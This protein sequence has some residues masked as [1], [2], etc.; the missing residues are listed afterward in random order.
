MSKL[1]EL[2]LNSMREFK[3]PKTLALI[4]LMAALAMVLNLVASISIGPYIKIGFSGLPNRI[5]EALFGPFV[6]CI[7]G[8]ALDIL[9]FLIKPDGTFFPGFTFDAML[10]GI[11]YGSILYRKEISLP[12]I[13]CAELLAKVIVNC[14]FNTYW[15]S[16]LYGKGFLA[17]LPLRLLKNAIMLPIDTIIVFICLTFV[18]QLTHKFRVVPFKRRTAVSG[19]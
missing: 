6:G 11:L 2:Y 5:V 18:A 19:E 17:L 8:G 15:I 16:V 4:G 13:F 9:K 1:K 7:F 10:A 14:G 3:S 12:R